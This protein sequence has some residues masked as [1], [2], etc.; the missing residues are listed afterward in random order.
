MHFLWVKCIGFKVKK[1]KKKSAM[2]SEDCTSNFL[3]SIWKIQ[4]TYFSKVYSFSEIV[5]D[6]IS[7]I[8]FVG[9]VLGV[10]MGT[11]NVRLLALTCPWAGPFS[12]QPVQSVSSASAKVVIATI[13]DLPHAIWFNWCSFHISVFWH[14]CKNSQQCYRVYLKYCKLYPRFTRMLLRNFT[15]F[16]F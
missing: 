10:W 8:S 1:K 12:V 11:A 4:N 6:G 5:H 9:F 14:Q 13:A 3:K 16:K 2:S 7:V 15:G